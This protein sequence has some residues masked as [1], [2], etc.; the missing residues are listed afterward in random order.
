MLMHKDTYDEFLLGFGKDG[1]FST[2]DV[3]VCLY[4]YI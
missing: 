1:I 4:L 3:S 2:K